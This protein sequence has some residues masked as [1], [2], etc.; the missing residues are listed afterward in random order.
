MREHLRNSVSRSIISHFK[1]A[2]VWRMIWK[3]A[4]L[5]AGSP[6]KETI[7]RVQVNKG[8][9]KPKRTVR[10]ERR[11]EM[12]MSGAQPRLD[13]GSDGGKR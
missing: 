10:R 4:R 2:T 9:T 1:S 5:E 13:A 12:E 8:K 6:A 7:M 11:G 3:W